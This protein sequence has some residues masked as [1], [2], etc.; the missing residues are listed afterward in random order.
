MLAAVITNLPSSI[1]FSQTIQAPEFRLHQHNHSQ[2][3][4]LPVPTVARY[5]ITLLELWCHWERSALANGPP[6]ILPVEQL[7]EFVGKVCLRSPTSQEYI[8]V[9][10]DRASLV[11]H[12]WRDKI[13]NKTAWHTPLALLVTVAVTLATAAFKDFAWISAGTLKGTFLAFLFCCLSWFFWEAGK[14]WQSKSA[15]A[16]DFIADLAEGTKQTD[17]VPQGQEK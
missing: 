17:Y 16:E 6:K 12:K 7:Q 11:F 10:Q 3:L 1:L 15:S 4:L 5:T 2:Q 8:I 14:A 13:K 9:N